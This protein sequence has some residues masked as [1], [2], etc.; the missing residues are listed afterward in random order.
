MKVNLSKELDNKSL[1]SHIILHKMSQSLLKHLTKD[2]RAE[3]TN[4]IIAEVKLTV[5]GEEINL[6]SFLD[7]WQSQVEDTIAEQA[8]EFMKEHFSDMMDL[9]S[10]LEC[11]LNDEID[12]RLEDWEKEE[13]TNKNRGNG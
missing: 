8:K 3:G 11:R 2:C 5:E 6:Q 7:Y 13:K 4:E 9:F 12:K 10:D 1:L